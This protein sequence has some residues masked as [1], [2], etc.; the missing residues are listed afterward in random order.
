MDQQLCILLYSK[1]S[2]MSKK[3]LEALQLCPINLETT[4][5]LQ[6]VCIDNKAVREQIL[7]STKIEVTVVP[8]LL[9]VFRN[10][11][12]EKYEGNSCLQWIDKTVDKYKPRDEIEPVKNKNVSCQYLSDKELSS[13][14]E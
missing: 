9:I 14:E 7:N 6:S 5:G 11:G 3:M 1:Y 12:V 13:S 8:C 2:P 4:I 10:G